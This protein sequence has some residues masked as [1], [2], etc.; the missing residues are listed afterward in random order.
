MEERENLPSTA[1]DTPPDDPIAD[2]SLSGPTLLFSTLLILSLIWA[3]W[4][5]L[6]GQRPWK[7]YQRDF[8]RLYANHLKKLEREQRAEEKRVTESAEYQQ[9]VQELEVA[10]REVASRVKEID[11]RVAFI[12]K[13]IEIVSRPFQDKRSR[14][15]AITYDLE[16][17]SSEKKKQ[18]YRN[19][20]QEVKNEA[21]EV[22]LLDEANPKAVKPQKLNFDQLQALFNQLKDE[23]AK[24][25]S[26]RVQLTEKVTELSKKR[27]NY[28]KENLIGLTPAQIRGLQEKLKQFPI[29]IKQINIEKIGLVDRCESCHL[30]TREPVILTAANMGRRREFISHPNRELLTIHDPERFGCTTCHNGNGRATKSIEYA[31]GTN[32]HWPWPLFPKGN[33]EAGCVQCHQNDRVLDHAP[34]LTKGRDLYQ[35]KGCVGCHRYE[36]FDKETDYLIAARQEMIKIET[37]QKANLLEIARLTREAD[38]A[39]SNEEAQQLN[40]QA[41]RLRVK[42]SELDARIDALNQ[43]AKYLMLDRKM[44]GPNLKEAK[45]KLRKEWIP[46]WLKDPQAFRP[47]TKMPRFRL[48]DDEVQ[49]LSAF[50]W[51]SAYS[52]PTLPPQKPGDPVRG[53]EAFESRGCLACHSI[54][55]GAGRIGG[56]FAANLSRLGEKTNLDYIVR[57]VHN[58][59]QR[60]RPYCPKEKRDLGPEDY[61]KH[62]LP[63]VFD[64]DHSTCPNDGYELQVVQMTVMPSFRLSEQEARDIATYLTSLK[65]NNVNYPPAPFMD[66]TKLAQRGREL[67]KRYGCANCHEIAGLE[68]E[69]RIGTELTKEG[70]K[71][72]PQLDFG[73][74]EQ[75]AR[76]EKW[77]NHKGFFER[78]LENPAIYDTGR[79]R[80][81]EDLLRMPNI[82]LTRDEI[83]A[84]TT[85]LL[86]SVETQIPVEFRAK[87]EGPAR[88]IQEG[89]WVVKKYNCMG[90]HVFMPGQQTALSQ[91]P[92]FQDAAMKAQLPPSL[93]QQG[94]R[95][96]PNWLLH[97]LNNPAL[98]PKNLD[99]NGVRSYLQVRMPT[100][101][102][103]P[104]ELQTL[105]NFF[106]ALAS[107]P[108][109]YIAKK[110]DP[111][112][113]EEQNLA[114]AL[115]TSKAA[116]CLKCHMTGNPAHDRLATAPNFLLAAERLK[117]DW[118]A[119]WL[120]DPQAIAPGTAMPSG[121]FKRD[122][123]RWVFAGPIPEAFKNYTKDHV[124]LL[125]RYMF[126][127]TPQEQA[128]LLA[129]SPMASASSASPGRPP[130]RRERVLRA[131]IS[132]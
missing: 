19:E 67:A 35:N 89:W 25:L 45:L 122:G 88:A 6:E 107:Q 39:R 93:I 7:D 64:Q 77:Y 57:W 32:K 15:A 43:K 10:E 125:V 103:S 46:V 26:E 92:R 72:L 59:R 81:R 82:E 28:L 42:N 21:V 30:G 75:K 38:R 41:E 108:Q 80:P 50:I 18:S 84:L 130:A 17:A 87:Q 71:P 8:V 117:P 48:T 56:D 68:N 5:E 11:Q 29:E 66:D 47:G 127:L 36:G 40:A 65:R 51:Q 3:L 37:T 79:E 52:S 85:L 94:A 104:N 124:Q 33:Y 16:H 70:S 116:P 22:E 91:L 128:R 2:K 58:P 121:L 27:E 74:L 69:Q 100:F 54:G 123:Q 132:H 106:E 1:D 120:I 97:F 23:K 49:A 44:V 95:V 12:N 112:T 73:L 105:V 102:F 24:L 96:N 34:I 61:A 131:A 20:I 31:H 110:L 83:Q 9:I 113:P 119:R 126:Q 101:Y 114:R 115:F 63:F 129:S 55:E 99:R 4:D 62:N 14:I 118:T 90:C 109:P 98:D 13:Q 111:L 76:E 86:G 53:K 78:K 60:S